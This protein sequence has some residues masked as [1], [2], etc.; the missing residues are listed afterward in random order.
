[1]PRR[2]HCRDCRLDWP[3]LALPKLRA[4]PR[5]R[6]ASP[7]PPPAAAARSL[8]G[9]TA[10]D[11]RLDWPLLALP[12]SRALPRSRIASPLLPPAAAALCLGVLT[13]RNCRLGLAVARVA[14]VV[15]VA[16]L[17]HR[18]A[19][20]AAACCGG[21]LALASSLPVTVA[22]AE[23]DRSRVRCLA[24]ASHRVAVVAANWYWTC[25]LHVANAYKHG[26]H[27][28]VGASVIRTII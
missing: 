1:L 13:A 4:L 21:K 25:L 20:A 14:G 5:S 11:C 16:S 6:I 27:S 9:L 22:L 24:P 2:P 18:V 3:L 23:R 26:V 10:R 15:C 7:L 8:G 19:I 12:E 17:P 28:A